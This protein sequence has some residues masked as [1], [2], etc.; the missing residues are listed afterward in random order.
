MVRILVPGA[1]DQAPPPPDLGDLREF[2][3]RA[4]NT[5]AVRVGAR[6]TADPV[7]T[8]D[9]N[10]DT[11]VE[12]TLDTGARFYHRYDQL[13]A[14]LP[15]T[16][17]RGG[18]AGT[19]TI[20]L[21]VVLPGPATR[22][23]VGGTIVE[24]VRTFDLDL[25][26][27]GDFAGGLAGKRIAEM[28]DNRRAAQYG[29]RTWS[30]DDGALGAGPIAATDLTG[31]DPILLFIHGTGSSTEGGFSALP[32]SIP[33]TAAP[34]VAT[35]KKLRDAY[36]K[37]IVA[38]D[39][40]TLSVSPVDNAI[41]LL[42]ALP[43]GARLHAV[44][45]SRGGM[46]GE[47]LCWPE[48]TDGK[49][50]FEDVIGNIRLRADRAGQDYSEQIAKLDQF[51]RLLQEKRPIMERFVRVACPAAGTTLAS[52][53]LDKWLSLA[54]SVLDLTG[55]GGSQ[56][57]QFLKG[58][59]LAVVKTRTDPRSVPGLEAMMPGS[60]L[61]MLLNRP[62]IETKADLSVISGD[63]EGGSLL[64]KIGLTAVDWFYGG[65]HDLVVDTLSM[66]GGLARTNQAARFFFD[67]ADTVSHFNYFRNDRTL[68]KMTGAL[69]RSADDDAGFH[70]IEPTKEISDFLSK[71]RAGGPRP[72]VILVPDCMGSHLSAN[73]KRVWIDLAALAD[74]DQLRL[75][76]GA[77]LT[78]DALVAD[79]YA[80]LVERLANSHDVVPFAYDWRLPLANSGSR[81]AS[82]VRAQLAANPSQP[83]RVVAHGA[84]GLVAATG[85]A[86]D[87]GLREQ[88]SGRA[89][90]RVLLLDL[91]LGGSTRIARLLLG[92]DRLT[93]HLMLL[94]LSGA[95][96]DI[97]E[98]FQGFPGLIDLL[99]AELLEPAL[100]Q[101]QQASGISAPADTLLEGARAQRKLIGSLGSLK[102]PLVQ[103]ERNTGAVDDD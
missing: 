97:T 83:V 71:K 65:D 87:D 46:I 31:S 50:P 36:G 8:L 17:T 38:F 43:G 2:G 72:S 34:R 4:E 102:L 61:T 30:L 59:L 9:V 94:S 40:P 86:A 57:Y 24:A 62:G 53:R 37:R 93:Q 74:F 44:S 103:V 12:L 88:F 6:R 66:Y 54:T 35:V 89:G 101:R 15:P 63:I 75:D 81:F 51:G 7:Q 22:G 45:H 79:A 47:L 39:H 20:D 26:T 27:L 78:P 21:P 10:P 98:T 33:G 64:A 67:K 19:D 68:G 25:S 49:A 80:P 60:L 70:R 92:R 77:P 11:I 85:F 48:R 18:A 58:F 28:F 99:P 41:E 3:A 96:K 90:A 91:P 84:G 1:T 55:L 76:K 16:R 14:D 100:W 23:G 13:A 69:L 32:W 5:K 29:L 82:L 42:K 52:G 95:T 73:G 56:L